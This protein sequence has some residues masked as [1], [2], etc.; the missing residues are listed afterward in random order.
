[1]KSQTAFGCAMAMLVLSN[2]CGCVPNPPCA[3]DPPTFVAI[4]SGADARAAYAR[5]HATTDD[6]GANQAEDAG[7]LSD[8]ISASNCRDFCSWV[9]RQCNS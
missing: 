8:T 3:N 2:A 9:Y 1:M 7:S 4:V 5:A 6:A